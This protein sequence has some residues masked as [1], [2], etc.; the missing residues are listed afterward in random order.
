MDATKIDMEQFRKRA[1]ERREQ[2]R[3]NR[4]FPVYV[5]GPVIEPDNSAS[6]R[7]LEW[8]E[9][10]F[11]IDGSEHL[12]LNA[13]DNILTGRFRYVGPTIEACHGACFPELASHCLLEVSNA[14]VLFAWIDR[15]DTLGT[16]AEIGAAHILKKTIFIA[17]LNHRLS[18][19]FYFAKQLADLAVLASSPGEA[20]A[21][22]TRWYEV[23]AMALPKRNDPE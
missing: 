2:A 11:Q 1:L 20:W 4:R 21:M 16:V 9:Q 7:V 6:G 5:A 23:E 3:I 15:E 18:E 14:E 12:N 17:F 19:Q 10:I 13:D 22:F 8:R